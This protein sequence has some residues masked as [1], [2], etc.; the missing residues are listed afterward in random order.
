MWLHCVSQS[1]P[2]LWMQGRPTGRLGGRGGGDHGRSLWL[3]QWGWSL[4][5]LQWQ[6][7]QATS[8]MSCH[9]KNKICMVTKRGDVKAGFQVSLAGRQA[10]AFCPPASGSQRRLC[11]PRPHPGLLIRDALGSASGHCREFPV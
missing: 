1:S 11:P 9:D 2:W 10:D 6:Q 5:R 4:E 3:R 8:V 7:W